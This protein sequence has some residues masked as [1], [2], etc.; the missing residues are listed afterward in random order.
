MTTIQIT[1]PDDLAQQAAS[2]G[3]LSP[4]AMET[5]LREQLKRRAGQTLMALWQQLPESV[6]ADLEREIDAEIERV[7]AR[8]H[9]SDAV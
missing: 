4:A 6:T 2:A 9:P 3:L 5:M 8:P 1:L 7:R